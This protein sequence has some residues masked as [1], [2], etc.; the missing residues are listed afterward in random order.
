MSALLQRRVTA[1]DYLAFEA[2]AETRHEFYDGRIVGMAG[3]TGDHG[4]LCLDVASALA[5]ASDPRGC[6]AFPSDVRVRVPDGAYFYPDASVACD[7]TFDDNN[8]TLNN[9]VLL[10][11]VLS[12]SSIG[13]DKGR[14]LTAYLQIPSL[15]AYWIFEQDEPRVMIVER[16][17]DLWALRHVSGLDGAIESDLFDTPLRMTD[18]YRRVEFPASDADSTQPVQ[19]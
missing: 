12:P 15:R 4:R 14:K 13:H 1:A 5:R 8:T 19:A 11:E 7:P 16:K 9:P 2:E 18:L 17:G 3:G 6:E 10:V